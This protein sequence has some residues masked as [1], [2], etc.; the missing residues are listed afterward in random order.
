LVIGVGESIYGGG[1]YADAGSPLVA[2]FDIPDECLL[3]TSE[4]A[5]FNPN[6]RVTTT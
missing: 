3:A 6:E 2:P 1:Y 4:V 5:L